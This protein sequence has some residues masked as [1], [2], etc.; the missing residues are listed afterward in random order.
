MDLTTKIETDFILDS[1]LNIILQEHKLWLDSNGTEG[2]K[3]D[4]SY[5]NFC[6]HDFGGWV[7]KKL[8]DLREIDFTGSNFRGARLN[9]VDLS[10]SNLSRANLSFASLN[11]TKLKE[12]NLN[13][14]MFIGIKPWNLY[15]TG[16]NFKGAILDIKLIALTHLHLLR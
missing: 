12:A 9:C 7:T 6:N 14:A 16:G 5:K 8:I 13:G 4:L 1:E 10:N 11:G 2:K 3:A 15:F